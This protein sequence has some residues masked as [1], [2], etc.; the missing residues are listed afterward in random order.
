MVTLEF[1]DRAMKFEVILDTL[2]NLLFGAS[3]LE[4]VVL[5]FF[6]VFSLRRPKQL[7]FWAMHTPHFL[8]AFWGFLLLNKLPKSH[9]IV[10]L[11]KPE[12]DAESLRPQNLSQFEADF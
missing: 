1:L 7:Y 6:F 11:I 4:I 9:E 5:G 10:E 12:K 3:F 8:H 2:H